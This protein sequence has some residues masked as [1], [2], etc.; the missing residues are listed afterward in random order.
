MYGLTEYIDGDRTI[1]KLQGYLL[2]TARDLAIINQSY[3]RFLK[4]PW[5]LWQIEIKISD[6][7]SC[8]LSLI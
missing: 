6:V 8:S 7:K 3:S 1:L 4:S 2:I 5:V